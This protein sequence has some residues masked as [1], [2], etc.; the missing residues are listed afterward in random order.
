M[1]DSKPVIVEFDNRDFLMKIFQRPYGEE[2]KNPST[3][4]MLSLNYGKLRG[5]IKECVKES[6]PAD[7][8]NY[9][10]T[11]SFHRN[12]ISQPLNV[13]DILGEKHIYEN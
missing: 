7:F 4:Y 13:S 8:E 10:Y 3:E 11:I 1:D 2:K 9:S 12:E 6:F 5:F